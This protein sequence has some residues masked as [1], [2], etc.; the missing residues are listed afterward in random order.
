M[1]L[2][3][4]MLHID[5]LFWLMLVLGTLGTLLFFRSLSGFLLEHVSYRTLFPY[6]VVFSILAFC[7]MLMV[8]HGDSKPQQKAS[9]LENF[10]VDD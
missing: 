3:R 4:G 9:I 6:A 10:D 2:T 7:T 8:K 5:A 1:L